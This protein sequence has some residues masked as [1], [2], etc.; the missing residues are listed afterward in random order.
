MC[1]A[2]TWSQQCWKSYASTSKI[3]A[4]NFGDHETKEMLGGIVSKVWPVSSFEQQL[5][6]TRNNLQQSVQTDATCNTQ[7]CLESLANNVAFV[8]MGLYNA[9]LSHQYRRHFFYFADQIS[10]EFRHVFLF[11]SV[12]WLFIHRVCPTECFRVISLSLAGLGGRE[13]R[14]I[15]RY[16]GF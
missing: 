16:K 7:Y 2:H 3:V 9:E 6:T 13:E 15:V 12:Q 14:T 5:P 4:L 11:S 1:N 10:E 8:S